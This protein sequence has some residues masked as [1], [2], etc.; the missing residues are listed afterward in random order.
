M[1]AWQVRTVLERV[2]RLTAREYLWRS[3]RGAARAAP[4][5]SH[6]V[7]QR[8]MQTPGVAGSSSGSEVNV[9]PRKDT[10][11]VKTKVKGYSRCSQRTWRPACWHD[12]GSHG[13]SWRR[14]TWWM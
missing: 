5:C 14:N 7:A 6:A 13:G 10:S 1:R 9:N 12:L 2:M 3:R 11:L 8:E 4:A